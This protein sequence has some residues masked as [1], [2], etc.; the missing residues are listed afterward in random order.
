MRFQKLFL[1]LLAVIIS[2][3]TTALVEAQTLQSRKPYQQMTLSERTAFV[4]LQAR[5]IARSMSGVD[6]EFTAE[7]ENEIQQEVE[8]YVRRIGNNG[9]DQL[10]KGDARF[11]F[12]RGQAV[13]PTLIRSFKAQNVSPLIGLYIPFIESEYVNIQTSNSV[14][15]IGM[16]QFLPKTGQRFGLNVQDLLD[17]EKSSG[18]AARYIAGNLDRFKEDKM[19]EALALLAYNRGERAVEGDLA[20]LVNERNSSCSICALTAGRDKLN[21]TFQTENVH[22]VP[23]FLAAAIIGE[24][25]QAFGLNQQ[26]L[27]SHK[28]YR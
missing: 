18:A 27:S 7:F 9:G 21:E 3:S 16:F 11:I 22:Y 6:Y 19:K 8:G 4:L 17:V 5:S 15:A 25:P 20:L 2:L 10:W 24:N 13:A 26:P 1:L 23:R 12:E 28:T 14:G